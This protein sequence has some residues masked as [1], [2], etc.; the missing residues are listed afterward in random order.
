VHV[1]LA[2]DVDDQIWP[3]HCIQGE[4][5]AELHADLDVRAS[6]IIVTKVCCLELFEKV[7]YGLLFESRPIS[8]LL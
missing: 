7:G 1:V 8:K 2:P 3:R 5:G 4:E 6:D